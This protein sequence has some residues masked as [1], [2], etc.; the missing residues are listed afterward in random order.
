MD[1]TI[2]PISRYSHTWLSSLDFFRLYS[3]LTECNQLEE[4]EFEKWFHELIHNPLIV[5]FGVTKSNQGTSQ[6]MTLVATAC[7]Y[8]Q[9][10]YY[11]NCAKSATIEDLVIDEQFQGQGVGSRLV[12]TIL[13]YT[14]EMKFYKVTLQCT[15]DKTHFYEKFGFKKTNNGMEYKLLSQTSGAA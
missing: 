7:L 12:S 15:D 2:T 5:L 1:L 3:R 11:R 9:P 6:R 4:S 14:N 8:I 13:E 10:R